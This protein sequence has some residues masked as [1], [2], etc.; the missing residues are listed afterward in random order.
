[1]KGEN[2]IHHA[3]GRTPVVRRNRTLALAA[4]L[5]AA[6]LVAAGCGS[7]ASSGGGNTG[8]GAGKP[9]IISDVT[10]ANWNCQFNPL[11]TSWPEGGPSE[12][13]VIYEPLMFI[14]ALQTGT[15]ASQGIHPW[16]ASS[17][18]WNSGLTAL[19]FT[20]RTGVKWNDGVAMT[21]AD[22]AYSFNVLKE[23]GALDT[24]SL[25]KAEGG[26]LT[27]VTTSGN[28][29]TLNFDA[30]SPTIFYA[31]AG[32]QPII[33]EHVWSKIA[34]SKMPTYPDNKPVGTG[35]YVVGSCSSSNLIYKANPHYWQPGKPAVKEVEWPAYLDNT[36]GNNCL[37]NGQCQWGGQYIPN[38][39][40]TY[41]A[42]SPGAYHNWA[43]A[44]TSV[45]LDFNLGLKNSPVDN[46]LVRQ[47]IALAIN[48]NEVGAIGETGSETGTPQDGIASGF[49]SG[50]WVDQTQANSYY[51]D[52]AFNTTQ[53]GKLLDQAG[54]TKMVGGV[55]ENSAGQK[56]SFTL[57]NNGG[58]SD[59]VADGT[60]IAQQLAKVGIQVTPRNESGNAWSSDMTLGHFELG[61]QDQVGGPGPEYEMRQ[62][63]LSGN[64]APIGKAAST[65][66]GRYSNPA[67]DAL[68]TQYGSTNDLA[69]QQAIVSK[70]EKVLL[71]DVPYIPVLGAVSWDQYN[72]A[73]FTGW[74]TAA[75]PYAQGQ[76][77]YPDW[78]WDL[79][80]IKPAS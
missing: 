60:V 18:S 59:W 38:I 9:L 12:T 44:I 19:T 24:Q 35:A 28:T 7:S 36:T 47:A 42:K 52:Y 20:I 71:S 39:A 50:G 16:L 2:P 41:L 61:I 10:G 43:P 54:Y 21:P 4:A 11:S 55:R 8:A 72:S 29:V 79:L 1:V 74:P 78:G 56:L 62:W 26:P 5:S 45:T 80:N 70:L 40:Q 69:T 67:T 15:Q 6:G 68:F 14:N 46:V 63:L 30:P 75:D 22:V 23:N 32:R 73:Q 76:T 65:N 27:S 66:F 31:A 17:Y 53:A 13:G 51:N 57:L 48:R 58:Y 34:P 33:P 77:A 37:I 49:R 64:T 25:W 3:Q